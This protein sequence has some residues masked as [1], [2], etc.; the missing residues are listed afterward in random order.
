MQATFLKRVLPFLLT[1][2]VGIGVSVVLSRLFHSKKTY[3]YRIS[4]SYGCDFRRSQHSG[5]WS[6]KR[7]PAVSIKHV[8]DGQLPPFFDSQMSEG[9][10]VIRMEALFGASGRVT[11]VRFPEFAPYQ[12]E[13]S[14][15]IQ[16]NARRIE[17]ELMESAAQQVRQID[18]RPLRSPQWLSV[19]TLISKKAPGRGCSSVMIKIR[20]QNGMR[21][22]GETLA[23]GR[24]CGANLPSF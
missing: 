1:L 17:Q 7:E 2:L 4:K 3:S 19:E 11:E 23:E 15:E 9:Q 13:A 12:V 24:R 6:P 14:S 5:T 18:F 10:T 21:W 20:D 22:E 8:P 16:R